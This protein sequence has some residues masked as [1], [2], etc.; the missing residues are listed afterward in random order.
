MKG[1]RTKPEIWISYWNAV[2]QCTSAYHPLLI[3]L[4]GRSCRGFQNAVLKSFPWVTGIQTILF[5]LTCIKVLHLYSKYL[6]VFKVISPSFR[7]SFVTLWKLSSMHHALCVT[8]QITKYL[9][10]LHNI[11]IL[12]SLTELHQ[13]ICTVTVWTFL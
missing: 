11:K 6:L 12:S 9:I 7:Q 3:D 8:A 2:L 10:T 13:N 4:E 5:F 1:N